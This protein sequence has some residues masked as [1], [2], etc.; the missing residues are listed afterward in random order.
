MRPEPVATTF[1]AAFR[2]RAL[3][4]GAVTGA[5]ALAGL[6]VVSL[7]AER[8]RSGLFGWPAI[9]ALVASAGAGLATLELVRRGYTEEQIGK[10][11][12][13]NLLRVM[14]EVQRI[15]GELQKEK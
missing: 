15:A 1:T 8:L 2:A 5:V 4:A 12:G 9:L 11:W 3:A 13:G 14:D 7:D 10:L 6:V